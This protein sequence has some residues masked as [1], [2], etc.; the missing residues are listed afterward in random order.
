[1]ADPR[2]QWR[3]LSVAQPNTAGLLRE[4]RG[5]INDAAS[6]AEGILGRYQEG[7]ELKAENEL[8]RRIGSRSQDELRTM[9]EQ[10]A[11][12][13]LNL[14]KNGLATLNSAVSGAADVANT[15]S[16]VRDR[17]GRLTIARN[18][19]GR[20]ATRFGWEGDDRADSLA[21]RDWQRENADLFLEGENRAFSQGTRGQ[22]E[23]VRAGDHVF[24]NADPGQGPVNGNTGPIQASG[25]TVLRLARTLQAEAGNQGAEGMLAV[26]A[27]I[28]NRAASGK[29]GDGIDGVIMKPGQ[30]SAW[31]SETG[32][33]GGE[34]GQNMNF[35]PNDEAMA[36]AQAIISGQYE[37]STQ[38]ATHYYNPAVSQPK[39]GG[40]VVGEVASSGFR[41]T[42][43]NRGG[44]R[45]ASAMA[46][47]GLFSGQEALNAIDP[48]R[49]A[50][51]AGQTEIDQQ[52]QAYTADV[53]AGVTQSV[54][55]SDNFQPGDLAGAQTSIQAALEAT[56][57]YSTA[58]A[59]GLASNAV[60]QIESDAALSAEFNR[61]A[62][63]DVQS[64]IIN[65]ALNNAMA[66]STREFKGQ[67]QYR[68]LNDIGRYTEDP[69]KNL[70]GDLGIGSDGETPDGYD[71]NVLRNYI[72]DL[73]DEFNV[74][75]AVMAVAMRDAFIRDP[76]RGGFPG[77]W[78]RNTIEN[79]FD[80]EQ[81]ASTV[82]QLTPQRRAEFDRARSELTINE[83][84][85]RQNATA[86]QQIEARLNRMDE[87]NPQR[88]SL[89]DRLDDLIKEA[90]A[91][92]RGSSNLQGR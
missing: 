76:G 23:F 49:D 35:Q 55:S 15:N 22:G 5:G 19:D 83:T 77:D 47:S 34:Q 7:A 36:V 42:T 82:Q 1:M 92:S 6:A 3:Q 54:V 81:I 46:E 9:F 12:D 29:Y 62:T 17:D 84:R 37:D 68:A 61:G 69:T 88:E 41:P 87:D 28:R 11:F 24:G 2:L 91:Y 90:A 43:P 26:G 40:P 10:G 70:E 8:A 48:I 59:A 66:Q 79:R 60:Q 72:N 67:D 13:D 71:S 64:A 27:V 30:F 89:E 38:G 57:E 73:A 39:W 86:Q 18:Q 74:E 16:I 75:P 80:K 4:V 58:E 85:L 33:A 32:Y 31:N 44:T 52:Q 25:D 20:A 14:G 65:E 50:A 45:Y 21:R 78:T 51:R 53:V 63:S 56:G